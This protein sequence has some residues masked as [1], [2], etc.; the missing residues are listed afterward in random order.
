MNHPMQETL[1]YEYMYLRFF[2]HT[3]NNQKLQHSHEDK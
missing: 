3:F 1:R 2:S